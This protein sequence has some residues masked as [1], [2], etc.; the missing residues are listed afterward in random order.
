MKTKAFIISL[1]FVVLVCGVFFVKPVGADSFYNWLQNPSFIIFEDF[2]E[3][4]GFEN[5]G[6]E[7]GKVY[8]NWSISSGSPTFS[9][10]KPHTG[11]YSMK[12]DTG[13][14]GVY[15]KLTSDYYILG[16]DIEELGVWFWSSNNLNF[17]YAFYYTDGTS[18]VYND[19]THAEN[20]WAYKD[21]SGD[22]DVSKVLKW[23]KLYSSST[24]IFFDDVVFMVDDGEGQDDITPNSSPWFRNIIPFVP[25]VGLSDTFGRID[26][27]SVYM[28]GEGNCIVQDISLLDSN[29]VHFLDLYYY[30][31]DSTDSSLKAIIYY[32]DGSSDYKIKDLTVND[33]WTYINFGVSFIAS[34]KFIKKVSFMV[35]GCSDNIYVDDV[36]L[37]SKL[38]VGFSRFEFS[39]I[40]ASTQKTSTGCMLSTSVQYV[41]SC[42]LYNNTGGLSFNGTYVLTDSTGSTSGNMTNGYFSYTVTVRTYTSDQ[43]ELFAIRIVTE[44]NV[45]NF[46]ITIIFDYVPSGAGDVSVTDDFLTNWFIYAIFL[47]VI[48]IAMTAY[49]SNLGENASSVLMLVTFLGSETLMSAISLS[50]GLIDTWF[51]LVVIIVDVLIILGLMKGRG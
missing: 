4:G 31:E 6:W 18:D 30:T 41:M 2:I 12:C 29:E 20:I 36:G 38:E 7:E 23:F 28:Y 16:S 44:T 14:A 48:P 42:Y 1:F 49:I 43:I 32:E 33:T 37:W 25:L 26:N 46:V 50:I 35:N 8:G 10:A 3:Y 21:I 9:L 40:P 45:Y 19:G 39:T 27:T 15:Y 17:D 34:D 5:A 47:V 11:Q 51:M 22:I 24:N 13:G